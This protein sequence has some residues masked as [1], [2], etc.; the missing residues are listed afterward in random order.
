MCMC[1]T[2]GRGRV[3]FASVR[4][5]PAVFRRLL[6]D[7]G[8]NFTH[9]NNEV[10]WVNNLETRPSLTCDSHFCNTYKTQAQKFRR[11]WNQDN[12]L[13]NTSPNPFMHSIASA[14]QT[15]PGDKFQAETAFL[16]F[17]RNFPNAKAFPGTSV[18]VLFPER[19]SDVP[20]ECKQ[21]VRIPESVVWAAAPPPVPRLLLSPNPATCFET[22][23]ESWGEFSRGENKRKGAPRRTAR[24]LKHVNA[25]LRNKC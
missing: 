5:P 1:C 14:S 7:A 15:M 9:C 23:C 11:N 3:H 25:S 21:D 4:L 24:F 22:T 18:R 13:L 12:I 19:V 8:R 20:S 6:T 10:S 16:E 17:W 2:S